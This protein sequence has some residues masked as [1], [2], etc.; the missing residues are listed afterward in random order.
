VAPLKAPLGALVVDTTSMSIEE[1]IK[2]VLEAVR[3][4]FPDPND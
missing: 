1:V 2:R 4:V 3:R